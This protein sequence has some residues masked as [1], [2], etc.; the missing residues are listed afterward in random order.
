MG[1]YGTAPIRSPSGRSWSSG[2]ENVWSA[3]AVPAWR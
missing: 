1:F 2:T 3:R